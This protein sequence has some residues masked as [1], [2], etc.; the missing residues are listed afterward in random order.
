[1][2]KAVRSAQDENVYFSMS[3]HSL[4]LQSAQYTGFQEPRIQALFST[5]GLHLQPIYSE[6]L[7]EDMQ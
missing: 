2:D 7:K 6:L 3:F 4:D 1:M 5:L